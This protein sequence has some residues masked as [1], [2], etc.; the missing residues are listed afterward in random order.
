MF[1]NSNNTYFKCFH[2]IIC[3]EEKREGETIYVKIL[4]MF[5]GFVSHPYKN[6]S[7]SIDRTMKVAFHHNEAQS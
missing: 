5:S 3:E 1:I 4:R 2:F 6:A 7:D